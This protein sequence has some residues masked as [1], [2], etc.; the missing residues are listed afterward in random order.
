MI[1]DDERRFWLSDLARTNDRVEALE[2]QL[3]TL[4]Q[5]VEKEAP[6]GG[7]YPQQQSIAFPSQ[8]KQPSAAAWANTLTK[9]KGDWEAQHKEECFLLSGPIYKKYNRLW[10]RR[11]P[12]GIQFDELEGAKLLS[13][14]IR[15]LEE[16]MH[17]KAAAYAGWHEGALL[18]RR[19]YDAVLIFVGFYF[20]EVANLCAVVT[21]FAGTPQRHLAWSLMEQYEL[22]ESPK[23]KSLPRPLTPVLTKP[24]LEIEPQDGH[25]LVSGRGGNATWRWVKEVS[26]TTMTVVSLRHENRKLYP[27]EI[28]ATFS[29][30]G[31]DEPNLP[32]ADVAFADFEVAHPFIYN[33]NEVTYHHA[34]EGRDSERRTFVIGVDE[35]RGQE[36]RLFDS[37]T[38]TSI[39]FSTLCYKRLHGNEGVIPLREPFENSTPK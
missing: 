35:R 6:C 28:Q 24:F 23:Q 36:L 4:R 17:H 26:H 7:A 16:E 21:T 39:G 13:V 1:L 30:Y 27:T 19:G 11:R 3:A 15:P 37:E 5:K 20:E 29:L 12:D 22:L 8:D 18:K 38:K 33:G 32:K 14:R 2:Q 31:W 9:M 34:D 25:I 10:V